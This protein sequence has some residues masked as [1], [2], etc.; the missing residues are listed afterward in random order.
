MDRWSGNVCL[1]TGASAG[2]GAEFVKDLVKKGV[3]VVACARRLQPLQHLKESL[4]N[5]KGKVFPIQCDLSSED[6][7]M[8]M[9]KEIETNQDLGR[10]DI[11]INNA[12]LSFK[13][14]LIE[15]HTDKLQQMIDVNILGANLCIQQS[16]KLMRKLG[17]EQ[18]QIININSNCG[19]RVYS[20]PGMRF[21]CATKFA[22]TGLT[23]AWRGELRDL[24][25]GIRVCQIS[26]GYIE[27]TDFFSTMMKEDENATFTPPP[28]IK[29]S[30]MVDAVNHVLSCPP[31]ME[32]NDIILRANVTPAEFGN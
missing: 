27:D 11:C 8:A 31:H 10:I 12:G 16:V 2:L 21:Y 4:S 23:R 9:F 29:A 14:P 6:D 17:I 32:I 24:K 25:S 26:P 5:E 30:D 13:D 7:I 20:A 19:H 18:G 22:L 28:G 1:V 15:F 3:N